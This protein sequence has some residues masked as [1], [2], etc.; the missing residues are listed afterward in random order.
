MI[1]SSLVE[2]NC[3]ALAISISRSFSPSLTAMEL[4]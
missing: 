1:V 2:H 3:L 4:E